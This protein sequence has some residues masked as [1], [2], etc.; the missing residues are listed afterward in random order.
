MGDAR[1]LLGKQVARALNDATL[2]RSRSFASKHGRP[3]RLAVLASPDPASRSYFRTIRLTSE[4]VSAQIERITVPENSTLA[5]IRKEVFR[6]NEDQTVDGILVQTPL[7]AGVRLDDAG[8]IVDRWKDVD[9]ITPY[10]SGLLYRGAKSALIPPTAKAVMEMLDF[11]RYGLEGLEVVI[12]GRSLVVGKPLGILVLGRHATVTWCHSKTHALPA[13][14]KRAEIL[15]TAIGRARMIDSK[16]V[17]P[18]ATV[19]DVGINVD[20]DGKLVG[21]LDTPSIQSI[22]GA[23]TPVPGGVGPVTTACLFNNLLDAT[24]ARHSMKA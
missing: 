8:L 7:P 24:F 15:I 14:C 10:Q 11:Y 12:V 13:I 19:I 20:E 2:E 18:S 4:E 22:A 3:P 1:I 6:L 16:Y 9:G 21:D 17:R 23:Y 5:D